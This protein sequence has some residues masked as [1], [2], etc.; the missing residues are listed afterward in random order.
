MRSVTSAAP[1]TDR[2]R[3]QGRPCQRRPHAQ[4]LPSPRSQPSPRRWRHVG[5]WRERIDIGTDDYNRDRR[6]NLDRRV[7]SEH[8]ARPCSSDRRNSRSASP[9]SRLAVSLRQRTQDGQ[10]QIPGA[11]KPRQTLQPRA[12]VTPTLKIP[13]R[14]E[15]IPTFMKSIAIP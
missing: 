15:P 9:L 5:R 13:V 3:R 12:R 4:R 2:R 11:R 10:H 7:A 1:A 14:R 8:P 6:T